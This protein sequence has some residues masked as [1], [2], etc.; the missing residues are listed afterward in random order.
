[1][2]DVADHVGLSASYFSSIFSH[3]VGETFVEYLTKLRIERAKELLRT[4]NMYL[5]EIAE[6]VGYN[7]PHYFST[8]FK[9]VA[10]HS[11]SDYRKPGATNI[12]ED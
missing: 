8:A 1:L 3:G 7:D 10:G 6:A 12:N 9:R 4:T 5:Y 11:P 2:P